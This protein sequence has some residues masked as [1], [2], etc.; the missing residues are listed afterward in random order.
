[1]IN[2]TTT[3]F[4]FLIIP[5]LYIKYDDTNI[6]LCFLSLC[7][8]FVPM[9][10]EN[11]IGTSYVRTYISKRATCT[12][13]FQCCSSRTRT[14]RAPR[15]HSRGKK[16]LR[17][18]VVEKNGGQRM[19]NFLAPLPRWLIFSIDDVN[20]IIHLSTYSKVATGVA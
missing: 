2:L 19:I 3:S 14:W 16:P 15:A 20:A 11:K 13:V 8:V 1:M 17:S 5:I 6:L 9:F 12:Y 7:I 4:V 10:F 18:T